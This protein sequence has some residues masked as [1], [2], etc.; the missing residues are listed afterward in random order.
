MLSRLA[1]FVTSHSRQV[2]LLALLIV[3]AAA[4]YGSSAVSHLSSGGFTDSSSPSTKADALLSER[5]HQGDPNLVFLLQSPSG[6]NSAGRLGP[7]GPGW[8]PT[9][10]ASPTSR[11]S[12]RTGRSH[13]RPGPGS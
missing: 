9:W 1:R 13:R 11:E 8:R 6:V 2:L 3:L 12:L 4:A 7:W 5:F 10:L